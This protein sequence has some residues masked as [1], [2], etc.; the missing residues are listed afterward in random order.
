MYSWIDG[1]EAAPPN[2]DSRQ[3]RMALSAFM[4]GVCLVTTVGEDGKREG[5]TINSFSSVSLQPPLVLW[6]IRDDARSADAFLGSGRFAIHVLA[7]EHQELALHFARPAPDKF[8]K[9]V[10]EFEAGLH[11]CPRLRGALATFECST[12]SRHKEGDHT[13]LIG[14]VERFSS[15]AAAPLVAH[16]GRLGP[17]DEIADALRKARETAS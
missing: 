17:V 5:M 1:L 4:T 16:A 3:L 9:Y 15:C 2:A 6:S 11:G 12:Y 8:E 13:I 14:R 10:S 7:E